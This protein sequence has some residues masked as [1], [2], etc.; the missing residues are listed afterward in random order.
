VVA[1]SSQDILERS[2]KSGSAYFSNVQL[3]SSEVKERKE[4]QVLVRPADARRNS[5]HSRISTYAALCSGVLLGSFA[6]WR[7]VRRRTQRSAVQMELMA[8]L[9]HELRTP[10]A[11]ILSAGENVRDGVVEDRDTLREQ[12]TIIITQAVRLT[13]LV[14]QAVLYASGKNMPRSGMRELYAAD[15][16][17]DAL[18]SVSILLEEE[19]ITVQRSIQPG[20]PAVTGDLPALS[21][22]L[23]NFITNAV[24]YGGESRWIEISAQIDPGANN[25]RKEIQ[26]GVRDRGLGIN[27]TE[28]PHI[29]EPFYR[30]RR[31]ARSP[32]RGSGLGLSIAK[33]G[34]EACGGRIS[35]VSEEGVGSVFTL[36]LPLREDRPKHR[37]IMKPG[38]R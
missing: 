2:R 37:H 13:A 19:G 20:L 35:V 8:S 3:E 14:D 5:R 29:F 16:V 30:S 4:Q 26:I 18:S 22:S 36:H 27:Q 7:T 11:A 25:G 12:G 17:N 28:L 24:K 9:S 33:S 21:Q 23:Q 10:I 15:L 6:L 1:S 32:I 31:V 34:A 38:T